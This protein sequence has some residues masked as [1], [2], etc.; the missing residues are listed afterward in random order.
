[1]EKSSKLSLT[2]LL[3]FG[4]IN[5]GLAQTNISVSSSQFRS[6]IS[7]MQSNID[8]QIRY[9]NALRY[10]SVMHC[11]TA[12]LQDACYYLT[13][14]LSKYNLCIAAYANVIDHQN[15]FNIYD[16]F[17][18]LSYAM[19]LYHD[20]QE[21]DELMYLENT[22]Q[23]GG[24][25]DIDSRFDLLIVKGDLL[26]A[27][28]KF[29]EAIEAYAEAMELKP[30]NSITQQKI[31]EVNNRRVELTNSLAEE[32]NREQMFYRLLR[33]GD[34]ELMANQFEKAINFY[35]QAMNLIPGNPIAYKKI[36]E[37][38]QLKQEYVDVTVVD[39]QTDEN[40]FSHI[41]AA[42]KDKNYSSEMRELSKTYISKKCFSIGQYK[43]IV[44]LFRVDDHKL[45]IIKYFY[46]FMDDTSKMYEFRNV[47]AYSSTKSKLD[48]FLLGK[49]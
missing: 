32:K 16:S 22:Y 34:A 19:K 37:A 18:R 36:K 28:N 39:C 45:E 6:C 41:I 49:E 8:E 17:S 47:F 31:I 4:V 11:T 9:N 2:V 3:L 14:D 44:G 33:Q 26:L 12:Q 40:E 25:N 7:T 43:E 13:S 38:N 29:D 48:E 46:D 21:R 30:R 5:F 24:A 27:S 20:T 10:F 23:L 1:M 35:E 15:F 42:I